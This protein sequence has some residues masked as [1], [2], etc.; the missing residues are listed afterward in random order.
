MKSDNSWFLSVWNSETSSTTHGPVSSKH[1]RRSCFNESHLVE[2]DSTSEKQF[3]RE[4]AGGGYSKVHYANINISKYSWTCWASGSRNVSQRG[5]G[6]WKLLQR[7]ASPSAPSR[8]PRDDRQTHRH[9]QT[10]ANINRQTY[11]HTETHRHRDTHRGTEIPAYTD[12][13]TNTQRDTQT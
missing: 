3:Q 9:S 8:C 2:D 11:K 5:T 13:H 7:H 1:W 12:T 10:H 4:K 6:D